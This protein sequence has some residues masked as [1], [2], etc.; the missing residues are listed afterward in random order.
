MK[1]IF[2]TLTI[3]VLLITI[4]APAVFAVDAALDSSAPAA[5][6]LK[7][8]KSTPKDGDKGMAVDNMGV[9]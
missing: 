9:K 5:G 6:T 8:E 4:S 2:A 1:R 3:A 7:I